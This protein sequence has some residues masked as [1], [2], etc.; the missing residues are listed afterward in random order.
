MSRVSSPASRGSA[1][2]QQV[3]QRVVPWVSFFTATRRDRSSGDTASFWAVLRIAPSLRSASFIFPALLPLLPLL[4]LLLLWWCLWL[5]CVCPFIL[6][7]TILKYFKQKCPA[8]KT[9]FELTLSCYT[10]ALRM[11]SW[12]PRNFY[13][14]KSI[15]TEFHVSVNSLK[16]QE[17]TCL[18]SS[19]LKCKLI[20]YFEDYPVAFRSLC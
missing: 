13:C 19:Y 1:C 6:I 11:K 16:N 2:R 18:I 3:L 20:V 9:E 5:E 10:C 15:F 4:L 14:L 7:A 17:W 12:C 8:L